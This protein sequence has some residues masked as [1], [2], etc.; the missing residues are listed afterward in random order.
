MLSVPAL[1]QVDAPDDVEKIIL[2]AWYPGTGEDISTIFNGPL[3]DVGNALRDIMIRGSR[4]TALLESADYQI[5]KTFST[6]DSIDLRYRIHSDKDLSLLWWASVETIRINETEI[7]ERTPGFKS[8]NN[9]LKD[10]YRM[11]VEVRPCAVS[12]EKTKCDFY[13]I[14]FKGGHR[15]P[16]ENHRKDIVCVATVT[17]NDTVPSA[18]MKCSD[19][20]PYPPRK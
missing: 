20:K 13:E 5:S 14:I 2:P 15:S 10:I 1:G 11:D 6:G 17:V 16:P 7:S 19:F 3:S 4:K 18:E 12:P 8:I 9:A